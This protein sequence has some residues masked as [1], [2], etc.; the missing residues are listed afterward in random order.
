[1]TYYEKYIKYKQKYLNLL[2][3]QTK[4]Y[5]RTIQNYEPTP[6][7]NW[8]EQGIKTYEG[9]LNKG[10][11]LNLKI[12]DTIIWSDKKGK[13]IKTT[14]TNLKYYSDFGEAFQDLKEKLIPIPNIT[15]Y[16]AKKLYWKFFNQKDIEKYGVIAIG[17]EPFK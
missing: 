4:I 8:I 11:W 6:W 7:L 15:V 2:G 1:M 14:V 16:D 3:G 17:V 5:E 12:G 9:R 13:R 10:D